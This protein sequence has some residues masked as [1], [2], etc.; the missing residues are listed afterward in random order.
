MLWVSQE[1]SEV[2]HRLST[3]KRSTTRDAAPIIIQSYPPEAAS[4]CTFILSFSNQHAVLACEINGLLESPDR[5]PK[6]AALPELLGAFP[7]KA[8]ND[9]A[10]KG[11]LSLCSIHW[12]RIDLKDE[13][14][15]NHKHLLWKPCEANSDEV[16]LHV[17]ASAVNNAKTGW[18][19]NAHSPPCTWL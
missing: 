4:T 6:A 16:R 9:T 19:R 10:L 5:N 3:A 11:S 1:G 15:T 8:V 13:I 7:T 17:D 14:H 12:Q 2:D 18:E